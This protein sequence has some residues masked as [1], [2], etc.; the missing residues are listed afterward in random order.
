MNQQ[1]DDDDAA[2]RVR[3]EEAESAS[4]DR[5]VHAQKSALNREN[6]I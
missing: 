3:S 5:Q 6:A 4:T 2:S 1:P